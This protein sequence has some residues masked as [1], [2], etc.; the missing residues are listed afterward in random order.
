M[1][2]RFAALCCLLASLLAQSAHAQ[3]IYQYRDAKGCIH[4]SNLKLDDKY[5]PFD[6]MAFML[7][8][9]FLYIIDRK[10]VV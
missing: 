4:L 7:E 6:Y 8:S 10:S 1:R 9:A 2:L 3:T 5:Q